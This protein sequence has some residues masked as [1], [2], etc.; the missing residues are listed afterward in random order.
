[1]D[2]INRDSIY[3]VFLEIFRLHHIMAHKLLEEIDLYPGQPPLLFM[4]NKMDGQSQK[5]LASRLH[6]KP[7]TVN[8]MIKRMEKESLIERRQDEEDQRIS[9]VHITDKGR[10][11]CKKANEMMKEMEDNMLVDLNSQEKIILRRLLLQVKDNL[12]EEEDQN[13]KAFRRKI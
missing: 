2:N 10:L 4:L 6:I 8:V 12:S 7:S 9:R 11:V 1:M 3:Y 5:D 13:S